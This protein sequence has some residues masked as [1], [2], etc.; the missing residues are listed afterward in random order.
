M[1]DLDRILRRAKKG[2]TL[3]EARVV[4]DTKQ[5][6]GEREYRKMKKTEK[7]SAA[8]QRETQSSKSVIR[9]LGKQMELTKEGSPESAALQKRINRLRKLL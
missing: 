3:N 7:Q 8:N 2:K 9:S 4:Q 1:K 5:R 6:M